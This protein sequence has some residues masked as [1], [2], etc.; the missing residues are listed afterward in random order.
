MSSMI[1]C[2]PTKT[3]AQNV[4]ASFS[5]MHDHCD[6]NK[7]AVLRFRVARKWEDIDFMATNKVTILDLLMIEE[8]GDTMHDIVPKKLIWK[9]NT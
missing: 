2:I 3:V 5:R 4:F 6:E 7:P 8:N 9:L 1:S